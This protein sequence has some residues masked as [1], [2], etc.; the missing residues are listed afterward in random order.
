M[1]HVGYVLLVVKVH[2]CN[3]M[4]FSREI[5]SQY[6]IL[7]VKSEHRVFK[8]CFP[9]CGEGSSLQLHGFLSRDE[10]NL[11]ITKKRIV[12]LWRVATTFKKLQ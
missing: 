1:W 9:F 11:D 3:F 5:L 12:Y 10:F 2:L 7:C 8:Y 6:L 4:V